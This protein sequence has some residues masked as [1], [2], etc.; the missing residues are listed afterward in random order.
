LNVHGHRL[1]ELTE[2]S[3]LLLCCFSAARQV[4]PAEQM[5]ED[6]LFWAECEEEEEEH[7]HPAL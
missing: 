1:Q 3:L 6:S 4:L 5:F 2:A 7:F